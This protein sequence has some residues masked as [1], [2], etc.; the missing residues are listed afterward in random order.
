MYRSVSLVKRLVFITAALLLT[1]VSAHA[2][3][4]TPDPAATAESSISGTAAVTV[5]SE[6]CPTPDAAVSASVFDPAFVAPTLP[7]GCVPSA[8]SWEAPPTSIPSSTVITQNIPLASLNVGDFTLFNPQGS[9]QFRFTLPDNWAVYDGTN[10]FALN[11]RFFQNLSADQTANGS[12]DLYVYLDNQLL[13]L[14]AIDTST[15]DAEQNFTVQLPYS[16]LSDPTRPTHLIRLNLDTFENCVNDI[17]SRLQVNSANS[18][19]NFQYV[20]TSPLLDLGQYPRPLYNNELPA[21]PATVLIVMPSTPTVNDWETAASLAAG[22]GMYTG[23]NSIVRVVRDAD[24]TAA[25]RQSSSLILVGQPEAN[26]LTAALYRAG[27]LPTRFENGQI[28]LDTTAVPAEN[29]VL[30]LIQ[31]PENASRAILVVTGQSDQALKKAAQALSDP[32]LRLGMRGTLSLIESVQPTASQPTDVITGTSFTFA[33][34]GYTADAL[35]TSGLG[36]NYLD[37][38]FTVPAGYLVGPNAAATLY[39]RFADM[40]GQSASVLTVYLN[41]TPIQSTYLN[42]SIQQTIGSAADGVYTLH[43]SIPPEAVRPGERNVLSFRLDVQGDWGCY[44]PTSDSLW[45]SVDP[46]SSVVMP[47][48]GVIAAGLTSLVSRFPVPFNDH[49]DLSNVWFSLPTTP[50]AEELQ[51]FIDYARSLGAAAP[52]GQ[53][54]AP[55]VSFGELPAEATSGGYHLIVWGLPSTNPVFAR[56]NANLPQPFVDGTDTIQQVIDNVVY[57]LPPNI[58][59]GILQVLPVPWSPEHTALVIT[60]TNP[61]AE[62]TAGA[63][64]VRRTVPGVTPEPVQLDGNV[65]FSRGSETTAINTLLIAEQQSAA[66]SA[67]SALSTQQAEAFATSTQSAAEAAAQTA[68]ALLPTATPTATL[69][70]ITVTP[71][72]TLVP[73]S[74]LQENVQP[75]IVA[76][77]FEP[78]ATPVTPTPFPTIP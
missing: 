3:E 20:E 29:G 26:T 5:S 65:V 52:L 13:T 70:S 18:S 33:D 76:T 59:L 44:P 61:Q 48:A 45:F 57:Q 51:Q 72:S 73:T 77:L 11:L 40:L 19:L 43:A 15:G 23:S 37:V 35:R 55:H 36:R 30:Q 9:A 7:T 67:L 58:A 28:T 54:F 75:Q 49:G 63:L 64:L 14:I 71:V 34:L 6:P 66:L 41:D 39:I 60:G 68:I 21:S 10:T 2:Q 38:Q 12:G 24:L 78:T 22:M 25:D 31:H 42:T 56:L 17:S 50:S 32:A 62:L 47:P 27:L 1:V 16:L 69:D 4:T 46:T 74:T 53:V 8:F